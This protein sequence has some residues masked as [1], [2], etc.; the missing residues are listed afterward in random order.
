MVW[1]GILQ[2]LLPLAGGALTLVVLHRRKEASEDETWLTPIGSE[3]V[4]IALAFAVFLWIL[5]AGALL[6]IPLLLILTLLS[7]AAR[8]EWSTHRRPR[9]LALSV[10]LL[11]LT[12]T[13]VLPVNEPVAPSSWGQ[14]LF[15]E[16]PEAPLY[17]ASEQYTWITSDVE[18]L[19]S[20]SMRLPHQT[21]VFGSEWTA[22]SLASLLNMET[23]RMHQAIALLDAE[24]TIVRLDPE[25]IVLEP[26]PAPS[27]LDVRL[28]DETIE[29]VEFRRYDIK[30]T[31][32]GLDSSGTKVGEVALSA[33][34]SWG[35]QLDML[36]L[37][38]PVGHPD[39][40]S[41][42]FGESLLREWLGERA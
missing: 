35:G 5:P 42:A 13:G 21:G 16:N 27:E 1:Q 37:V 23:G 33:V 9:L 22:L 18:I 31:A 25:T 11:C 7:P 2:S 10:A 34:S 17:P 12:A 26:V 28:S 36:V 30:S 39:L 19:Q 14:P 24:V 4:K 3:G 20:V 40:E 32:F 29:T 6:S 41:D 15:T 8:E 38:R